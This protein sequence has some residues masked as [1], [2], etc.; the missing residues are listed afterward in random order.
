M[1]KSLL[2][3]T[4]L[5]VFFNF[6]QIAN[7]NAQE[8]C[9]IQPLGGPDALPWG[10][11]KPFPWKSIG[12]V[13]K[14]SDQGVVYINFKIVQTFQRQKK[15]NV[16]VYNTT[17]CDKPFMRGVGT[18]NFNEPNVVRV[19]LKDELGSDRLMK[20]AMFD[21]KTL[22]LNDLICG[23]NILVASMIEIM[24]AISNKDLLEDSAKMVLK[25]A[26][27]SIVPICKNQSFG[28]N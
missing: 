14:I 9:E 16:E 26:G 27:D 1:K 22:Q 18:I 11:A 17:N 15:L 5:A 4:F 8:S 12:G 20:I 13:W 2:L 6:T 28:R 10:N 23:S 19:K 7:L 24:P 21:S 3:F 25:Y